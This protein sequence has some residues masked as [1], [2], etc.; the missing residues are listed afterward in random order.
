MAAASSSPGQAL[1]YMAEMEQVERAGGDVTEV[2]FVNEGNRAGG[3]EAAAL[4]HCGEEQGK[5]P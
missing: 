1:E 4:P 3:T 2:G 5:I